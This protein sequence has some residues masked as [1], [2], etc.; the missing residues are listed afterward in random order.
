MLENTPENT[1]NGHKPVAV[2]NEFQMR[3]GHKLIKDYWTSLRG[4]SLPSLVFNRNV[5]VT[6]L[7]FFNTGR[8]VQE[9]IF[10]CWWQRWKL[11]EL[12]FT[13]NCSH[14]ARMKVR[15]FFTAFWE[16]TKYKLIIV[17]QE[18]VINLLMIITRK[19]HLW[20]EMVRLQVSVDNITVAMIW[21][22]DIIIHMEFL[23]PKFWMLQCSCPELVTKIRQSS[24]KMLLQ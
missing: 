23:D 24:K 14:I 3:K 15:N 5:W 8:F 9:G 12:K 19:I 7:K 13:S 2:T 18:N 22:R 6:L 1:I 4:K 16:L 11:Q 20:K 10:S 17:T 21:N